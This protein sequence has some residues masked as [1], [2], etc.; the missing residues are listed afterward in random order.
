MKNIH[1]L[2]VF[3]GNKGAIV[4]AFEVTI[5]LPNIVLLVVLLVL[6]IVHF[7]KKKYNTLSSVKPLSVINSSNLLHFDIKSQ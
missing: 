7:Y 6:R 5:I 1:S 3:I 4:G 2:V